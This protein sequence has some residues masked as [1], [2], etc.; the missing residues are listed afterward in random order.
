MDN[1]VAFNP[2]NLGPSGNPS[3]DEYINALAADGSG[4]YFTRRSKNTGTTGKDFIEDLYFAGFS[5]DSTKTAAKLTYPPGQENDAGGL[6][7]SPDGRLLFFTACFRANGFGSCD[8]YFSEKTGDEWSEARNMG[9]L[10]NS[11]A[12]EA[13]QSI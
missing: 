8:L 1:P 2:V 9:N 3:Y 13:Q 10:V 12:W 7:I 11:E 5:A 6:C 4:I